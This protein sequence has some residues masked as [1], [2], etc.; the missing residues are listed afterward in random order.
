MSYRFICIYLVLFSVLPA[1]YA[2]NATIDWKVT[3]NQYFTLHH[4]APD[5]GIVPIIIEALTRGV[6]TNN[7]FFGQ[8][9]PRRFDVWCFPDRA[10]LDRQW[11]HDWGD[12]SFH[13]ACWMVA[14]GVAHRLDLLSPRVWKTQACD[15]G[16]PVVVA[17]SGALPLND[18]DSADF[19]RLLTHELT[20]VYHG[21]HCRVP[22]FTGMDALGWWVEGL[23]TYASGQLD[24]TRLARVQT[25]LKENKIPARLDQF[26]SGPHRYGLSGSVVAALDTRIERTGLLQLLKLSN[27]AELFNALQMKEEE[28]LEVWKTYLNGPRE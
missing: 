22:D 5:S 11:Q 25:L 4:T 3:E 26:W 21:Q 12:T 20:H 13:S 15:H 9:F 2:Q 19:Q 8:P 14:S 18:K 10:S 23:A 28:I 27:P 17:G 1:G 7:T 6:A 24:S 16:N